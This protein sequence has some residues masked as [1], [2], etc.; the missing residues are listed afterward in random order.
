MS[1]FLTDPKQILIIDDELDICFLLKNLLGSHNFTTV[2]VNSINAAN[3]ALQSLQPDVVFLDNHLPDG[4]GI[5]YLETLKTK[6][7][8]AKII[9][10]TAHDSPAERALAI[11]LGASAFIGKPFNRESIYNSVTYVLRN[12]S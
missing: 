5:N 8:Q 1:K 10:I 2:S 6:I 12:A 3:K 4:L 11:E 9:M 7:P